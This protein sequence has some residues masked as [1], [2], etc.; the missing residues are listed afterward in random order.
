MI[1]QVLAHAKK[2]SP[3]LI[4]RLIL[5]QWGADVQVNVSRII[6]SVYLLD[7]GKELFWCILGVGHH[8]QSPSL[9]LVPYHLEFPTW[10]PSNTLGHSRD[11]MVMVE[12][13]QPFKTSFHI[14]QTHWWP[15]KQGP[16]QVTWHLLSQAGDC[17]SLMHCFL[18]STW[19]EI[20][21]TASSQSYFHTHEP[22]STPSQILY[23]P[24]RHANHHNF[25]NFLLHTF[26]HR[27]YP[28]TEAQ[29][30]SFHTILP[31]LQLREHTLMSASHQLYPI[32]NEIL[33]IML[34]A[35]PSCTVHLHYLRNQT[36]TYFWS[37]HDYNH[38]SNCCQMTPDQLA[39]EHDPFLPARTIPA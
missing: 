34:P 31:H 38:Q 29:S 21:W 15:S 30:Q 32:I 8:I 36:T 7:E 10:M 24:C 35:I 28:L 33:D 14:I 12:H 17:F 19:I 22:S 9:L 11:Q 1:W 16:S 25:H 23:L 20:S 18:L 2:P 13:I 27:P 3:Q 37:L 4:T 39:D 6:P 26:T 5:P